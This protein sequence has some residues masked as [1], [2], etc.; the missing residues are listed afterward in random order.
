VPTKLTKAEQAT[1][2]DDFRQWSGGF[3]PAECSE[4]EIAT[5]V[6]TAIWVQL[7]SQ[8]V[9]NFLLDGR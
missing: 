5:Y 8:P 7:P 6:E 4:E 2:L 9:R 1:V 3:D